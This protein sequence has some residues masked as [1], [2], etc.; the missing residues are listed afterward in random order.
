MILNDLPISYMIRQNLPGDPGG[1]FA[2]ID[3][4]LIANN[5]LDNR[6]LLTQADAASLFDDD[7]HPVVVLN[8]FQDGFHCVAR[9]SRNPTGSHADDHF[10]LTGGGLGFA[11]FEDFFADSG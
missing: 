11:F 10:D 8:I 7:S 4:R 9:S 3:H 5:Y 2:V 6:L 1:N